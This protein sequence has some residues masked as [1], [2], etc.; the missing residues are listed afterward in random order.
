MDAKPTK[1]ITLD[2][3]KQQGVFDVLSEV[4]ADAGEFDGVMVVALI[5]HGR[6]YQAVR[7]YH[8]GLNRLERGGILEEAGELV[9]NPS[10]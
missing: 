5:N 4:L 6:D 7:I 1:L 2:G 8:S 3:T 9:R 10:D